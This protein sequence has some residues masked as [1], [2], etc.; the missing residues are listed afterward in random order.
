MHDEAEHGNIDQELLPRDQ[1]DSNKSRVRIWVRIIAL[2]MIAYSVIT[3]YIV[4]YQFGMILS[5]S[6]P[7]IFLLTVCGIPTLL[8]LIPS[9]LGLL[10]LKRSGIVS[11]T[12]FL[13]IFGI[14][15]GIIIVISGPSGDFIRFILSLMATLVIPGGI[16]Y[17]MS[18]NRGLFEK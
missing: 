1:I 17:W 13:G 16:I 12:A 5:P 10:R 3:D 6:F 7:L 14:I 2:Y 11:A 18:A 9:V 4:A 8:I 15:P